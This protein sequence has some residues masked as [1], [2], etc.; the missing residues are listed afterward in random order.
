MR[1][2][3]LNTTTYIALLQAEGTDTNGL[4]VHNY[5][6]DIAGNHRKNQDFGDDILVCDHGAIGNNRLTGRILTGSVVDEYQY[7]ATG[8]MTASPAHKE[9]HYD[10]RGR[11]EKVVRRDGMVIEIGYDFTGQRAFKRVTQGTQVKESFYLD[12]FFE[13]DAGTIRQMVKDPLH[14]VEQQSEDTDRALLS[15][16]FSS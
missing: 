9:L 3:V 8:N 14:A 16:G 10:P 7:D 5:N 11:L 13:I 15:S 6:Y 2:A 1:L 12:G 4:Y